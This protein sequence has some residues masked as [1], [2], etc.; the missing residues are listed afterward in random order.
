MDESSLM[1]RPRCVCKDQRKRDYAANNSLRTKPFHHCT[2]QDMRNSVSVSRREDLCGWEINQLV[3]LHDDLG[4]VEWF[5]D[6]ERQIF[7]TANRAGWC[8]RSLF[9]CV[10]SRS[11]DNR[12]QTTQTDVSTMNIFSA[13]LHQ[14]SLRRDNFNNPEM[15]SSMTQIKSDKKDRENRQHFFLNKPQGHKSKADISD[16]YRTL[17]ERG[18]RLPGRYKAVESALNPSPKYVTWREDLQKRE[19]QRST[20]VWKIYDNL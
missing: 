5:S 16:P 7:P 2:T 17:E 14:I 18:R 6:E 9:G 12:L 13:Q 4:I 8:R 1:L 11:T 15:K 10:A 3:L 19:S 20:R